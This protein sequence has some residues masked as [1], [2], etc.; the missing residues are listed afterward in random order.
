MTRADAASLPLRARIMAI[1]I[2][3]AILP[4]AMIGAWL[5]ASAARSGRALLQTEL[6]S[7]LADVSRR[8]VDRWQYREAE[9]ALLA[10]NQP[11]QRVLAGVAPDSDAVKY[12]HE[13]TRTLRPTIQEFAYRDSRGQVRW[14]S[15]RM[16]DEQ[17]SGMRML[18]GFDANEAILVRRPVI[19]AK[20]ATVG[21]LE[22]RVLLSGMLP[23]DSLRF[24]VAGA[25]L[26]IHN[27][28][29]DEWI[30]GPPSAIAAS[31]MTSSR[32]MQL[33]RLDLRLSASDA[34]YVQPFAHA[35]RLGLF[36]LLIVAGVALALTTF[37]SR[38]L[39][40]ALEE[41]VD[42]AGAVASGD[43]ER[44]VPRQSDD[45]VGRLATAFNAMT[46]SLRRT[47][48]N[49]SQREAL[50]AVG[51]FAATISHEIRNALTSVRLDLQRLQERLPASADRDLAKRALRNVQRLN[52]IVTGSLRIA[53]TNA[54]TMRPIVV[55]GVLRTAM[56]AAEPAFLENSAEARLVVRDGE[57]PRVRGD[58]GALEQC[59]VNL[60][61]NA[62]QA[63]PTGGTADISL[64]TIESS[65]IV[66][67]VDRGCGMQPDQ[68]A[69]LGEPFSSSK[70]NGTG[71]GYPI[72]RQIALAHG[73]DVRV[74][75][76]SSSGTTVEVLLP[77]L[78]PT[79]A[80]RIPPSASVVRGGLAAGNPGATND[81]I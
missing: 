12:F 46:E 29:T 70:P 62:A 61:M 41:L 49:L 16:P 79:T 25:A 39:T 55:E 48:L 4:L 24:I 57:R 10:N 81:S 67:I 22:A 26:A 77:S 52:S 8:I 75:V 72:A 73:G 63:M 3:G 42:A 40:K 15:E 38:R 45:E 5:T 21:H 53:R 1:V 64:D 59:F 80:D 78:N 74:V 68:L 11:A 7:S 60:L 34:R 17:V 58:A 76:T 50:A 9:L 44:S 18:A 30:G 28:E 71:L 14:S 27:R 20:G 35:A 6:D 65:V 32:E 47:L 54:E 51:Q 23:T 56:T 13:L 33:P 66:R 36:L 69:R 43:L 19:N 37:L 2:G 31:L